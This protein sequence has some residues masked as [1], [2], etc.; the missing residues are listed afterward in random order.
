MSRS[1]PKNPAHKM[2]RE[3]DE[4][5]IKAGRFALKHMKRRSK[6]K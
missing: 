5:R 3:A 2:T 6:R 1:K 4:A